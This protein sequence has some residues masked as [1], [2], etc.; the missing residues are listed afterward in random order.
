MSIL[1][2]R[3]LAILNRITLDYGNWKRVYIATNHGYKFQDSQ[4]SYVQWEGAEG[5]LRAV[6]GVNLD[7]LRGCLDLLSFAK[8]N[9]GWQT[10]PTQGNWFPDAFVDSMGRCKLRSRERQKRYPPASKMRLTQ[11][12]RLNRLHF[13]QRNGVGLKS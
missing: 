3:G 4:R 5:A 6:M 2:V 7:C 11:C 8:L 1:Y 12:E 9:E 13:K 10:L